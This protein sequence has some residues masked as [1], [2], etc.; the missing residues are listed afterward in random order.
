MKRYAR[1]QKASHISSHNDASNYICEV[2]GQNTSLAAKRK[3]DPENYNLSNQ[4]KNG[5]CT[6]S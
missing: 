2:A 1:G 3:R 4:V 5:R 6:I